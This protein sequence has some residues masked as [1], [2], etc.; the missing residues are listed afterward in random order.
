M[1]VSDKE[2]ELYLPEQEINKSV[3]T[4]SEKINEDYENKDPLFI[5]TLNG[6]FIFAADLLREV[7]TPCEISFIKV[8][9]YSDMQS[10]GNIKDLI[11]LNE[12]I[13]NRHVVLVEDI[14]D[15]GRTISHLIDKLKELGPKS[16]EVVSLLVKENKSKVSPTYK[17]F[18]IPDYFM[19]GYGLDYNGYG[20]HFKDIYRLK[21]KINE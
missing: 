5:P 12:T 15:T 20:R 8:A 6:A 19:V 17:G 14:I 9:S 16:L 13:F 11:G 3:S 2:F 18:E 4:L 10:S 1:K 21:G 7:K